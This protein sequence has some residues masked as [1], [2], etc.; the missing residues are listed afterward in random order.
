[1]LFFRKLYLRSKIYNWSVSVTV[2]QSSGLSRDNYNIFDTPSIL[3]PV[4]ALAMI[5]KV[6]TFFTGICIYYVA[7][8]QQ[9]MTVLLNEGDFRC[10]SSACLHNIEQ[11]QPPGQH[12]STPLTETCT[13]TAKRD[14]LLPRRHAVKR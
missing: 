3:S 6:I 1:M 9:Q 8:Q 2:C 13:H 7:L 4:L 10:D 5:N 14:T 11:Q 12:Q